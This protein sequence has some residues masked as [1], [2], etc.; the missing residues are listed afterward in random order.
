[1]EGQEED[2]VESVAG[3]NGRER[4]KKMEKRRRSRG[5]RE[6]LPRDEDG[7]VSPRSLMTLLSVFFFL[8]LERQAIRE[9]GKR[10]ETEIEIEDLADTSAAVGK[11]MPVLLTRH[12]LTGKEFCRSLP[13]QAAD[14]VPDSFCRTEETGKRTPPAISSF[15]VVKDLPFCLSS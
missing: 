11:N 10:Q 8:P 2:G 14:A 12:P 5:N 9:T 4:E 7:T 13:M 1:M 6:L 15:I 3:K